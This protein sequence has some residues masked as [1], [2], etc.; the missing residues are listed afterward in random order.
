[1]VEPQASW[2]S[3]GQTTASAVPLHDAVQQR[4]DI[5]ST[6]RRDDQHV[7][8]PQCALR[9]DAASA[10]FALLAA[11][12]L[13]AHGHGCADQRGCPPLAGHTAPHSTRLGG[14][15]GEQ[16]VRTSNC[17]PA[18]DRVSAFAVRSRATAS[19]FN[20][21]HPLSRRHS[22]DTSRPCP[23]VHSSTRSPWLTAATSAVCSRTTKCRPMWCRSRR[24]RS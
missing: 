23:L 19:L 1:M 22:A 14:H 8:C 7:T 4:S 17:T 18:A 20:A 9:I 21:C 6:A 2:L 5:A 24:P 11:T 15:D 13:H 16:E 3:A 12:P 10:S